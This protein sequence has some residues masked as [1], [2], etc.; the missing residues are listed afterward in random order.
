MEGETVLHLD[1][2]GYIMP[3]D[4]SDQLFNRD[5][6]RVDLESEFKTFTRQV[7]RA[8]EDGDKEAL[9]ELM[10]FGPGERYC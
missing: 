1:E 5:R 7:K 9:E 4:Q 2:L 10:L 8:Y 3:D 6:Q